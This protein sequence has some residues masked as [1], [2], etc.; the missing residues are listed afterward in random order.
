MSSITTSAIDTPSRRS[1]ERICDDLALA[2]L[3]AVAL[4]AGL[5]FREYGRGWDDYT[6]AEYADLLLRMFGSGFT[7]T[8]ALSFA[9]L[10]MYGGGFDLAGAL[11]HKVIPLELFETRRLLGAVVGVVGLAVTWRLGRRVGGPLAGR[12]TPLLL[13]LCS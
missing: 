3:A 6:H 1:L 11:L 2:V 10:Y 4:V 12:A 13:A 8:S 7:D 5:A 9:N